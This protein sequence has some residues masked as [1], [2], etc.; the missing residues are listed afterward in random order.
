MRFGKPPLWAVFRLR[1]TPKQSLGGF[2]TG[3]GDLVSIL[4]EGGIHKVY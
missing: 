2:A 3:V 1:M 4:A